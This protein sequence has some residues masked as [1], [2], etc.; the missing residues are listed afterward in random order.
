[1]TEPNIRKEYERWLDD[2][3]LAEFPSDPLH[4]NQVSYPWEAFQAA[5]QRGRELER[6]EASKQEPVGYRCEWPTSGG[7]SDDYI[8]VILLELDTKEGK[9]D[10][11]MA[12]EANFKMLPLYAKPIP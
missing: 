9:L 10:Y 4:P 3:H 5:I 1:M 2:S 8:S 6:E 11:Q 7:D 12:L